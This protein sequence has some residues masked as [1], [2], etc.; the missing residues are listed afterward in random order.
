MNQGLRLTSSVTRS[1][2]AAWLALLAGALMAASVIAVWYVINER[3][4]QHIDL[5]TEHSSQMNELL[6]RQDIDNRVSALE[7]LARRW[8]TTGAAA[9]ADWEADAARYVTDMPGFQSVE[10]ADAS[11]HIR[12]I[13]PLAGNETQLGEEISQI[14]SVREALVDV[15][16][17]VDAV[18]TRPFE[19]V[20]GGLGVAIFVPVTRDGQF[21]G[22]IS[23]I[24]HLESWLTAVIESVQS[25]DYHV[26]LLLDGQEAYRFNPDSGSIDDS[27][28]ERSEFNVHGLSGA[29]LITPTTSF[30]SAGHAESSSLVLIVGLLL[31]GFVA[32]AV[33]LTMVA[34]VRSR[35]L[36]DTAVQLET[37]IQSLPGIAFRRTSDPGFLMEFVSEGCRKLTG[38]SHD[39]FETQTASWGDLVHPDDRDQV[40]TTLQKAAD[41]NAV[42]ETEYRLVAREQQVRWMWERGCA[43]HSERNNATVL[44]GFISDITDRK[45]TE[46]A[47]VESQAYS[48]AIVQTAADAIITIDAASRVENVNRAAEQMFGYT[49]AEAVG[50]NVSMLMPKGNQPDHGNDLA[51]FVSNDESAIVTSGREVMAQRKDGSSFPIY[52]SISEIKGRPER[53]FVGLIKDISDQRAAEEEARR[54]RENLAHVDRLNML[55]EMATGI[56]HEINQPLTAISLFARAGG[57][58]IGTGKEDRMPEIFDKLNQHAYRASAVI[59]RVQNMARRRESAKEIIDCNELVQDVAKLAETEARFRDMTIEVQAENRTLPVFVDAVQVQQVAL[60]LLRNGMEAMDSIDCRNGSS[61]QL[62]TISRDDEIEVAVTDCGA[63]VSDEIA[64]TLFS[65]FSTTKRSGLGMGLSISRSIITAHGGRLD[66]HKNGAGG[67]T[68]FFT[69]PVADQEAG[70]G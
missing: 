38:Y 43:V 20:R 66:F 42:Y 46:T 14:E 2:N 57:K 24:L 30:L 15:R 10:W 4:H 55:G 34:R 6:I 63:G 50:Q 7:R 47:L 1:R 61:L 3:A 5:A 60:N 70:D 11:M 36:H 17:T 33:Y 28:T 58:L 69:L 12:W 9:R 13:V 62:Q 67:A 56:A 49:S 37:L 35:Q 18:L 54:H 39:D 23:G 32:V 53:K 45:Q 26:R 31:S 59:E 65:P 44:E 21:D 25:H 41:D 8:P 19:L 52:L 64:E 22:V 40:L 51:G 29:M 48:Q 68:F 27:R 16:E